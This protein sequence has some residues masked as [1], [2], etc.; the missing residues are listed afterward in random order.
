MRAEI[1][2][3]GDEVLEGRTLNTNAAFLGR[4]LS[5]LGYEI[6]RNSTLRDDPEQIIQGMKE[7][8]ARSSV[9]ITTGGLGPTIDD[10]TLLTAQKLLGNTSTPL[11]NPVGTCPG[12]LFRHQGHLLVLLPGPPYEMEAIFEQSVRPH[13]SKGPW[14]MLEMQLCFVKELEI[15]PLLR[16]IQGENPDVKIGIYPSLGTVQLRFAVKERMERFKSWQEKIQRAFPTHCFDAPSIAEAVH[17]KL[18]ET[19]FT[20]SLAESCTGGALAA[21]LVAFPDA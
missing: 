9:V 8:L 6:Y 21:R 15:D 4:Q 1:L 10:L 7:A 17:R 14:H 19:G 3:I 13:L 20:L 11:H 16:K 2:A 5:H 12:H 18:I